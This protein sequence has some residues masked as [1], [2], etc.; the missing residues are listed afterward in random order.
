M[1]DQ[2]TITTAKLSK[3]RMSKEKKNVDKTAGFM[4][5]CGINTK[6]HAYFI[7][8]DNYIHFEFF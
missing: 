7:R 6:S 5:S 3:T 8:F 1:I 4:F 2:I